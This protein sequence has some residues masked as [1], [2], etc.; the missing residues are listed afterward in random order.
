MVVDPT[1]C[2]SSS[3][4]NSSS[5]GRNSVVH[6]YCKNEWKN[7]KSCFFHC[8]FPT[9]T[10]CQAVSR[11]VMVVD[12]SSGSSSSSSS[13]SVVVDLYWKK[14]MEKHNELFFNWFFQRLRPVRL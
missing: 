5:S 2:S 7:T 14:A 13:R 1:S 9:I 3:N 11:I 12:L 4:S 8:L 6:L 10:G